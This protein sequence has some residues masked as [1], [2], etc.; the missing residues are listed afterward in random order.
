MGETTNSCLAI[1]RKTLHSPARL[2]N[3]AII[4]H[5]DHGKTTLVDQLSKPAALTVIEVIM[6]VALPPTQ[7]RHFTMVRC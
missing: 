6:Y 4:A 7:R 5:V 1:P 3:L 2:S